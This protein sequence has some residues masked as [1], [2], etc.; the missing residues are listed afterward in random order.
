MA[1][2]LPGWACAKRGLPASFPYSAS[3]VG[4]RGAEDMTV[5][6]PNHSARCAIR[7]EGGPAWALQVRWRSPSPVPGWFN[8]AR[9]QPR[10]CT[11]LRLTSAGSFFT[12]EAGQ[13]AVPRPG[14]PCLSA[15]AERLQMRGPDTS[16]G[17]AEADPAVCP[18]LPLPWRSCDLGRSLR[19][20][21]RLSAA[22]AGRSLLVPRS[23]R[24][25]SLDRRPKPADLASR[26]ALQFPVLPKQRGCRW[27][28]ARKLVS[29]SRC[30]RGSPGLRQRSLA[31]LGAG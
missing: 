4:D 5:T 25:D 13:G 2:G 17:A 10:L 22:P 27:A 11:W 8:S 9:A 16:V 29:G 19:W 12:A 26:R 31:R 30:G 14:M 15:E 3:R 18:I 7:H 21:R 28:R 6:L 1:P 23:R 24:S 20:R